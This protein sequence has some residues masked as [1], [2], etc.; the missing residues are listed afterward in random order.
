MILPFKFE[1]V[2]V[3]TLLRRYLQNTLYNVDY[4]INLYGWIVYIYPST[5]ENVPYK[6]IDLN[7]ICN[8]CQKFFQN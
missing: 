1:I 3:Y 7:N 6:C 2:F 5:S 8:L 4:E